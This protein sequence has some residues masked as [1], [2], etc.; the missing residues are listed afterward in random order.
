MSIVVGASVTRFRR[1]RRA[2]LG[3]QSRRINGYR[4]IPKLLAALERATADKPGTLNQTVGD[5]AWTR[6][7]P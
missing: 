6:E 3:G 2:T 1:R 5:F 7:A 4:E